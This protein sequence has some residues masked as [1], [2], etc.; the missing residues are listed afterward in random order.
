[1]QLLLARVEVLL[2]VQQ[3]VA[4][5]FASAFAVAYGDGRRR[6]TPARVE[7]FLQIARKVR[8]AARV[9][10]EDARR[11]VVGVEARAEEHV[12]LA[13][14]VASPPFLTQRGAVVAWECEHRGSRATESFGWCLRIFGSFLFN[15]ATCKYAR[16]FFVLILFY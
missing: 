16:L 12:V 5:A 8:G 4:S 14:V 15:K 3:L 10:V 9:C 6:R 7:R 1:M 11:T 2:M 13:L